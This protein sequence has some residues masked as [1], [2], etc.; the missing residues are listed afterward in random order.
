[1]HEYLQPIIAKAVSGVNHTPCK[2]GN[3]TCHREDE[4]PETRPMSVRSL[5]IR[6]RGICEWAPYEGR[7]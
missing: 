6:D 5:R 3:I 4:L 1:M 7:K 2:T